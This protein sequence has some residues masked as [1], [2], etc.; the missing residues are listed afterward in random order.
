MNINWKEYREIEKIVNKKISQR[1]GVLK[2]QMIEDLE[3]EKGM[4]SMDVLLYLQGKVPK[5][6]RVKGMAKEKKRRKK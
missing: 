5:E 2:K 1:F 4:I 3:E 6:E